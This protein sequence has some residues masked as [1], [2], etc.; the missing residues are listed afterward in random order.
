MVLKS[1]KKNCFFWPTNNKLE[2]DQTR[3]IKKLKSQKIFQF[4]I[5][6]SVFNISKILFL[7]ILYIYFY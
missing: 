7:I 2:K 6:D 5:L 4:S 1:N 3:N